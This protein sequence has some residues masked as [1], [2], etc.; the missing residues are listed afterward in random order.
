MGAWDWLK[1]ALARGFFPSVRW[2]TDC[3]LERGGRLGGICEKHGAS[4]HAPAACMQ[5]HQHLG[6]PT[7]TVGQ[8]A[9]QD[10]PLPATVAVSPLQPGTIDEFETWPEDPEVLREANEIVRV[11]MLDG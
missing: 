8:V 10:T 9:C 11:A 6:R 5:P 4:M 7:W 1:Q 2:R 3:L